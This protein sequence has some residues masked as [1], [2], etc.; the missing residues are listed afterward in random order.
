MKSLIFATMASLAKAGHDGGE[1]PGTVGPYLGN[2]DGFGNMTIEGHPSL[3]YNGLYEQSDNWNDQ[4]HFINERS[5]HL[6]FY[7]QNE[8]GSF[9]WSLDGRNQTQL[10]VA[11]MK[12]WYKGGWMT[13]KGY[14]DCDLEKVFKDGEI[15]TKTI[16]SAPGC[17]SSNC[18]IYF[19]LKLGAVRLGVSTVAML[20]AALMA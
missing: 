16:L 17:K 2:R 8:G 15:V 7:N 10:E 9:G 18:L 3:E 12:D 14:S 13:C 11:G 5:M 1:T 6:Y 4:P 19:Y 20:S